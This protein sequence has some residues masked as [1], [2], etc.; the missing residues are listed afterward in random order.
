MRSS[1]TQTTF[2][3][4]LLTVMP[5][6]ATTI[7]GNTTIT[8]SL[9]TSSDK[10][11]YSSDGKQRI[12]FQNNNKTIFQGYGAPTG[13][14]NAFEWRNAA[15]TS[16]AGLNDNGNMF[17]ANQI[18]CKLYVAPANPHDFIGINYDNPGMGNYTL[19]I[20]QGSFTGFHRSIINGLESAQSSRS[21]RHRV[22]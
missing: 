14:D 9:T 13:S 22:D 7:N 11:I 12:Y 21:R 17:F 1:T 15:G 3:K 8:G 18:S 16:I 6:G 2:D 19:Y 4:R 5:D 10:W 20:I